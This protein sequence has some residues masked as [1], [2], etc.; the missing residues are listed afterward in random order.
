MPEHAQTPSS[1]AMADDMA[2]LF[3]DTNILL[4]YKPLREIDWKSVANAKA[5]RL[6][7]CSP[8]LDELDDKKN[9]A[10][11]A[12][13]ARSAISQLKQ[14]ERAQGHVRNDV[15]LELVSDDEEANGN[16]D[17]AIIRRVK[18]Y[19]GEHEGQRMAVVSDD[20]NMGLRCKTKGVEC[21]E[22]DDQWRK[23]VEDENAR[24]ARQLQEKLQRLENRLPEL[25]VAAFHTNQNGEQREFSQ[26]LNPEVPAPDIERELVAVK[27]K[28]RKAAPPREPSTRGLAIGFLKQ[29]YEPG[30]I[31][32][33]NKDLEAFY[34]AYREYM[35]AVHEAEKERARSIIF[36]LWLWNSGG[37]PAS[38]IKVTVSFPDLFSKVLSK[39]KASWP[40]P[41]SPPDPPRGKYSAMLGLGKFRIPNI[42]DRLRHLTLPD[43]H[44]NVSDP[45][46]RR[47]SGYKV[48][49]GVR[50][51]M[52]KSGC[53]LGSFI[54]T[55][56]SWDVVRPFE[57][58][59]TIFVQ[60]L[61]DLTEGEI[62]FR[63]TQANQSSP[64]EDDRK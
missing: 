35:L 19:C 52:H 3:L 39:E 31:A 20:Y 13:R 22:L 61:P 6:V 42:T 5:V 40:S 7:L 9:D 44:R 64:G 46:I 47:G 16:R 38:E 8:V 37:Q 11:T 56:N 28:W 53:N 32:R 4:H 41:P 50:S 36:D 57:A 17:A 63:V 21:I 49:V 45:D 12:E 23:P 26:T 59:Y 2:V 62:L 58:E 14:I 1:S 55:F 60:E 54:A 51:L 29:A 48:T 25:S 15:T 43:L 34:E 27:Q 24:K 33:Y 10:K 18:D 30:E